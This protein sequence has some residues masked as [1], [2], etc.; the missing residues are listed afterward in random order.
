VLTSRIA[1]YVIRMSGG[2]GGALSDG[3]PYRR[4]SSV[5]LPWLFGS[6]LQRIRLAKGLFAILYNQKVL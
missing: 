1:G 4:S 5:L 2:V 3:C 6:A